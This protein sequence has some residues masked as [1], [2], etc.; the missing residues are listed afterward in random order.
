MKLLVTGRTGQIARSLVDIAGNGNRLDGGAI[1]VV[2]LGRPELD[3]TDRASI[4][5]A[6]AR[7]APDVVVS[8]AAYTAVDR[9]ESDR[10]A[11]LAVNR[12]G[13]ANVAI[14]AAA[15]G[16]PL[17][18]LSTD[19]VFDGEKRGPYVETDA[20]APLGVYGASKLAG[21]AAILG[22][23]EGVVILR[24]AWVFSPHGSNFLKTILRLAGE[25][26]T[27]RV[28]ADRRGNP[29]YAPDIA[30]AILDVARRLADRPAGDGGVTP[31]GIFHMAASGQASWADF[32]AEIL[33][34]S[35]DRG[36]PFA[37]IEPIGTEAYAAP[38]Q[39][40]A[41]S[42]LDSSRFAAT[43][44]RR[45]PRWQDGVASGLKVLLP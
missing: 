26:D 1:A 12:D 25:R 38:A 23:H 5:R 41:H 33:S 39:R 30:G 34:Q 4:E 6:I 20:T 21:E 36:G 44:Q 27:L 15:A 42:C 45:L 28:V 43:F 40:P 17:I 16:L 14:A 7:H 18:H 29:T 37:R 8:A 19:Y 24:T 2:A 10:A 9:A 35:R 32:A 3:I 31:R 13:A 22:A 11:A